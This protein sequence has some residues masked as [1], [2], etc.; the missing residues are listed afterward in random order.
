M[1]KASITVEGFLSADPRISTTPSGKTVANLS[2]PVTP[3]KRD[4]DRYVDDGETVWYEAALW[5]E[6]GEIA[7]NL[8]KGDV[9]RVSSDRLEVHQYAKKDGSQGV[10]V[11]LLFA[12]AALVRRGRAQE[13]RGRANTAPADQWATP[14]QNGPQGGAWGSDDLPTF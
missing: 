9:V 10:S 5:G 4:G 8:A 1:A 2:I 7:M 3:Q 12:S 14:G 6:A 13:P 11:R